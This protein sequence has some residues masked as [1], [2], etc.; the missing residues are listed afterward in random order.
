MR[1]AQRGALVQI[2][3]GNILSCRYAWMNIAAYGYAVGNDI[4]SLRTDTRTRAPTFNS[5]ARIVPHCA[6]AITVPASPKR[7]S[8]CNRQY[9]NDEQYSRNGFACI[10]AHDVRSANKPNCCSLMRF[11]S[12]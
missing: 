8:A 11:S 9:A 3:I 7:R 2:R 12:R 10:F 1:L 4:Q 6:F 5:F